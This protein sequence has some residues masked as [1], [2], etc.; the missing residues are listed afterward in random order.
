MDDRVRRLRARLQAC[1]RGRAP[2][3]VRYPAE[4]RAEVVRLAREGQGAG[5]QAGA[6]AKQLGLPAATITRWGGPAPHPRVR[7]IRIAAGPPAVTASPAAPVLVTPQG[8]R[9]E[10]LDVA[11]L[12]RVLQLGT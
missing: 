6:L 7:R 8:W 4:L 5:V 2:R 10:G 9:I 3:G 12:L 11:T 1:S